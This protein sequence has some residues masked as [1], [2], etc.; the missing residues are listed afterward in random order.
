MKPANFKNAITVDKAIQLGK[1]VI[2]GTRVP[3]DLIVGKI[4]G[5]MTVQD[6]MNEYDLTDQQ[7]FA[8]LRKIDTK[9]IRFTTTQRKALEKGRMNKQNGNFLNFD[10]L[11]ASLWEKN[12]DHVL[13]TTQPSL[14]R[15]DIGGV[16]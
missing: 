12:F 3:V 10:E 2:A 15:R 5:G 4:A 7:V 16:V 9:E 14:F 8:V 6:V 13:V 11:L 1:P